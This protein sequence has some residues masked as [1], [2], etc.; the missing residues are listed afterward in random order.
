VHAWAQLLRAHAAL[1]RRFSSELLGAHGLTLNDYEV[2]LH[3]AHAA[4]RRLRPVDLAESVL[5]TPSGITRLLGGLERAGYVTRAAC[6]GDARVSYAV[7]TEDGYEKLR[8]AA[9]SHLGAIR[10]LFGERF[11]D[12]ELETLAALLERLHGL[13]G[14]PECEPPS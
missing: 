2:L 14:A 13:G 7:L 5:L 9:P 6:P 12:D 11:S 3:L 8:A 1:T 10:E 4:E